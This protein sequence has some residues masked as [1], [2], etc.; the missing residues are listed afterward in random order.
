MWGL[1]EEGDGDVWPR[2]AGRKDLRKT[3]CDDES[4]VGSA[5]GAVAATTLGL[6]PPVV[7]KGWKSETGVLCSKKN[8]PT[9]GPHSV[10]H[11]QHAPS[12]L[13]ETNGEVEV[14]SY[15]SCATAPVFGE[16]GPL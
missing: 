3:W 2:R 15:C 10:T 12:N 11:V 14:P 16:G 7:K 1:C 13:D 9:F 5:S 4:A 8:K 6:W